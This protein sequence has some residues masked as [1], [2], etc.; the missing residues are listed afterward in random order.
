MLIMCYK[1]EKIYYL[2]PH[3]L[4]DFSCPARY[5]ENLSNEMSIRISVTGEI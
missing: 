2:T 4:P 3:T 1:N 5:M